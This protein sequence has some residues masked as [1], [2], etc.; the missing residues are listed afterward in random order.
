MVKKKRYEVVWSDMA[1]QELKDV[2]SYIKRQ[3]EPA[4]KQVKNKILSST[5]VLETGKEIYK[6]DTLKVNNDGT[7]RAYIVY[8]YRIVYRI[9]SSQ[10]M[11]LRIRHTS[12]EPLEY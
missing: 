11:I 7:Y 5:K 3:S 8:S 12:R 2:H 10:I 9:T 1:K 4:A 6:A